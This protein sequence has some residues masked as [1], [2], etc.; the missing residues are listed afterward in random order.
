MISPETI[1]A[2]KDSVTTRTIEVNGVT[3]TT[4]EVF[5]LRRKDPEPAILEMH[6]LGGLVDYFK[7]GLD[8]EQI[9]G[10]FLHIVSHAEVRIVGQLFGRFQQR[11]T[12]AVAT[13][14]NLFGKSFQFGAQYDRELFNVALQSL[15]VETPARAK[16]LSLVGNIKE[17]MVKQ[18]ADDGITQSVNAKAGIALVKEV[19]APNPVRLEPFRTFRE[20]DQ[21]ESAFVFRMKADPQRGLLCA[22]HEAD[23]GAWKLTAIERIQTYLERRTENLIIVG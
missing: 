6:T 18:T 13:F 23:G 16:L 1:E 14:E 19:E 3:Y 8:S 17:E 20:L 9:K 21:P 11:I 2:V 12:F 4:R 15:F 22:L 7:N 5:D 10:A